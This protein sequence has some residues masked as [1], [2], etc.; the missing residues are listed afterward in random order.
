MNVS[1]IRS[2]GLQSLFMCYTKQLWGRWACFSYGV[3]VGALIMMDAEDGSTLGD[4]DAADNGSTVSMT[5]SLADTFHGNSLWC[6]EKGTFE[7]YQIFV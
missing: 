5:E 2:V 6:N 4:E 3:L 7:F 1:V